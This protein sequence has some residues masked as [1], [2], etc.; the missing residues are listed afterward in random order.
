MGVSLAEAR[1][2]G[3][4]SARVSV[5]RLAAL[6]LVF[7]GA[8]L[9][10]TLH[11]GVVPSSGMAALAKPRPPES[12]PGEVL[13]KFKAGTGK[14]Q[15]DA[16]EKD[17]A[18]RTRR[19]FRNGGEHWILG[20][21]VST[22]EA[23]ARLRRNPRIEYA[24][25]N[26]IVHAE[27]VPDDPIYP[28]LW[29]LH[30]TG[31]D[32]GTP[33]ADIHAENAWQVTTGN[34]SVVVGVIDTGIDYRHQD[35]A[36]NIYR[37]PREIPGNGIDDDGNGF[38]DDVR[39]WDFA[40]D[41][42]DPDDDA[43]HGTHVAGTIGAVGN[44]GVGVV[45]VAWSVSLVPIKFLG[46][47][48]SGSTS[49]AIAA[50]E[51]ATEIGAVITNNSW[52]GAPFSQSLSDAI[53][54]AGAAGSLFVAAAGNDAGNDDLVP[55][56]PS[57]YAAANI[58]SVAATD[59]HDLLASFSNY[60]ASSVDL[61]AP[62]VEITSTLPGGQYG[63]ASG[64]SMAAPH[65]T[66]A[67]ALLKSVEPQ[68]GVT[69]LKSRLLTLADPLPSLAGRTVSGG[70][71]NAFL[72]V[73]G[74][75]TIPPGA[76][77]D[78]AA[79]SSNSFTVTLAWT[80]TGDDG[81][82]GTA[83]TYDIR[84][85]TAPIDS[86]NFG[87]ATP[88]PG[89]I[90][91][92]EAGSSERF[93]VRGLAASTTY[94]F[95]L[96]AL[97]EWETAGPI[98]NV[99]IGMTLGPPDVSVEPASVAA[100]LLVGGAATRTVT[101]RNDGAGDL[102]FDL[103]VRKPGIATISPTA[104]IDL[105]GRPTGFARAE[106]APVRPAAPGT[107]GSL[108]VLLYECGADPFEIQRLLKAFPD[109]ATIDVRSGYRPVPL[110]STLLQYDAVLLDV[111]EPCLDVDALGDVLADYADAGGGVVETEVA[112]YDRWTLHGRFER[113]GYHPL[114]EERPG[115]SSSSLGAF[116]ATHP[117]LAGVT[118]AT[119]KVVKDVTPAPGAVVLAEWASGEPFVAVKGPNV[120]AVNVFLFGTGRWTGDVPLLLRN[121]LAWAA[122]THVG[123]LTA[124]PS[125]GVVPPGG[126]A[127]I[128]LRF[129]AGGL[130]AG[131]HDAALVVRTDD[132]DE[133][134]IA[135]PVRLSAA[136]APDIEVSGQE[137]F[138]E[139]SRDYVTAGA[140][141]AH[142]L[143]AP[144]P[145]SGPGFIDL[146]A[147]GDHDGDTP[148]EAANFYVENSF[149][150]VDNTGASCVPAGLTLSMDEAELV[151]LLSDGHLDVQVA[152]GPNADASCPI[153][154][155]IIR[156]RYS[157]P[158]SGLDFG[159]V[160]T[161]GS[162]VLRFSIANAGSDALEVSD[163]SSNN[164]AF[165]PDVGAL[166]L[167]PG[168]R[169]GIDVTFAPG[170][171]GTSHG[172]LTIASNDP[173][174][175]LRTMELRG[176]GALEP[177]IAVTPNRLEAAGAVGEV[178]QRTLTID[179]HGDGPLAF[180]VSP[181]VD[182]GGLPAE[183]PDTV[184]VIQ[185]EQPMN[186]IANEVV[187]WSNGVSY[188]TIRSA[189]IAATDLSAYRVVI[190]AGAQSSSYYAALAARQGQFDS[191]VASGGVLEYH[192][193][194]A[195]WIDHESPFHL[196]GGGTT[197]FFE[198]H[199]NTLLL[200]GHPL[201]AGLSG[202]TFVAGSAAFVP[203][204]PPNAVRVAEAGP[205]QTTIAVSS[206]G[207]GFVVFETTLLEWYWQGF[208]GPWFLLETL[209]P[210]AH[211]LPLAP[212]SI[213]PSSGEIPP[214][215][216]RAIT[217]TFDSARLPA[218]D[219]DDL[220]V[221]RSNDADE[222]IV[223]VPLH[224]DIQGVPDLRLSVTALD[225]GTLFLDAVATR[226]LRI[227][228]VGIEALSVTLQSDSP[229]YS[230][231][232]AS[233][234]V[235]PFGSASVTV[236]FRADAEGIQAGTLR[237]LSN[238]PDDPE[239]TVGLSATV[240]RPP[241]LA[242]SP[243]SLLAT[244]PENRQ[245]TVVLVISNPGGTDLAFH[246]ERDVLW[247]RPFSLS[248]QVAPGASTTVAV[249]LDAGAAPPGSYQSSLRVLSNDPVR[250]LVEIPASLTVQR[251]R[252]HDGLADVADNCPDLPNSG[253]QDGDADG[254]GDVCDSCPTVP[255]P[256]QED[257]DGDLRGDACDNCPSVSNPNQADLDADGRGSLCDN[258]PD[259][260]NPGQEDANGDGAGDACQPRLVVGALVRDGAT[261]RLPA[262]VEEPQGEPVT[263]TVRLSGALDASIRLG[264]IF[265]TN[266]CADGYFPDAAS[267]KGLG[268]TYGDGFSTLFDLDAVIGCED[269]V[270]DFLLAPG[271]CAGNGNL[272]QPYLE[273]AG[274]DLPATVCVQ[275]TGGPKSELRIL[276]YDTEAIDLHLTQANAVI[277]QAPFTNRLPSP[278]V[279][280]GLVEGTPY[281][282]ELSATDG[283][284]PPVL[285][286]M[287]FSYGGE[288]ELRFNARPSA[289]VSGAGTF[290]CQSPQ[291]AP[292][293]LDGTGS[294][295]AGP[296]GVTGAL[297]YEW[298]RDP[299][300][301]SEILLGTGGV[302]GLT[303][304]L[305]MNVLALRVTDADAESDTASFTVSVLDTVA[306]TFTLQSDPAVLWPPNHGLRPVHATW[307]VTDLC[308]PAPSVKL[309]S[310][311]S[312]EPDDA[313][314]GGD[315]STTDDVA[316]ADAGTADADFLL[317]AERSASG[318]GR[319]YTLV[320]RALDG[321]GNV[322]VAMA[323]V[324]VPHDSG[325]PTEPVILQVD[326]VSG[327]GKLRLSWTGMA[328]ASGYDVI[329]GDLAAPR[330]S[331]GVFDL[332]TV[333]VLARGIATTT[334]METGAA[335]TPPPGHAFFY[336]VQPRNAG[337][338]LGYGTESAPWPRVPSACAGGCP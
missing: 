158:A 88:A 38:V 244:L 13:V 215:A 196:P 89:L 175:P 142:S 224:I 223:R 31:Q 190:L 59:R 118:A 106:V 285:A 249:I 42:N 28:E 282:I 240:L 306:P 218:G 174:E 7:L 229:L 288:T 75:E 98:S 6:A 280:S 22:D 74:P 318:A 143:A 187:L 147:I 67:A 136:G 53:E 278:I 197:H 122:G 308:D 96:R 64:T 30:N 125:V 307:T 290:E 137:V 70:R 14:S 140:F 113:D 329:A 148:G 12:R 193:W 301:P 159:A 243:A 226:T 234:T 95:A 93:E 309:V 254:R 24:E 269:G 273:L 330:V 252:D 100:D 239:V 205:G 275:P 91:P 84:Y 45:G 279:L 111:N 302:L 235:P 198:A 263:G 315:G 85:S 320:Y 304:P 134:Q 180:T 102:H 206:F 72:S 124:D 277:V 338:G 41:D 261:L 284:T 191:Y 211:E 210:Y 68:I 219:R 276:Q 79:V 86:A 44:N 258:C 316:G 203:D 49:D 117:I 321:T 73:S 236:Q 66:G 216:G 296:G 104:G 189:A 165:V 213:E 171:G 15:K 328:G 21:G 259:A 11:S 200:P 155:N 128:T 310:A 71:L 131:T 116:D 56:Y 260:A 323:R 43:G 19:R 286:R 266:D 123:W 209:I 228:N 126:H 217:V 262:R 186:S 163:L 294:S 305:G 295:E 322:A 232:P 208:I 101:I 109:L 204:L 87:A 293:V 297:T 178:F 194:S 227:D 199:D 99:A 241:V 311:T 48:G 298:L 324:D 287:D 313:P 81:A 242:L 17:I 114:L 10:A 274:L 5:P 152:N 253:Q 327:D 248:G 271:A 268:Y 188:D 63:L 167:L 27:G 303:L 335:L 58:V 92:S 141:T 108:R 183:P 336:L 250:P 77:L 173:D 181:E 119:S 292:V 272:F 221:V 179:N 94:Y 247:L 65:V 185:D 82:V 37:N 267:R 112:F 36:A 170:G 78:L 182:R 168:E 80:A 225:F 132:P 332:G 264:D 331:N 326:H 62:G 55:H 83:T 222:P 312:S 257:H 214:G 251:D 238:D 127:D 149:M 3:T 138:V 151:A 103:A 300:T 212:I 16:I 129:D 166:T 25:P 299:G 317:R 160:P 195:A 39:G 265:V 26:F 255:N 145:P 2:R 314:G 161:G 333:S 144:V 146:V 325:I 233:L 135:V 18:G 29:S 237:L 291:G 192:A 172:T 156:L 35:L 47:D 130:S 201:A 107:P 32:G 1:T 76:V 90:A 157:G 46:A 97:D 23:I 202:P 139:S 162:R 150:P 57:G 60:G 61:A 337:G 246:L 154:R 334:L 51:Y 230:V 33:G 34:R 319:S 115:S 270:P 177:E 281:A 105:P 121:A 289:E 133:G 69:E 4:R 231:A 50:I 283:K 20:A 9:F 8:P 110:L 164:P 153:N 220:L 176:E 184:L 54:D 120:V 40:N 52:G 207:R 169:R 256:L 245:A